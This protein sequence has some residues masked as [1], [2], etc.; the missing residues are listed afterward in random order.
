MGLILF[1][2][3]QYDLSRRFLVRA[4]QADPTNNA[5][6]GYLG[7]AMMRLNR[8]NEGTKW[9]NSAGSGSW[10]ACLQPVTTATPPPL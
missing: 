5:A 2:A 1:A 3:R 8:V 10:T 9:I 4:V 6:K 7:C